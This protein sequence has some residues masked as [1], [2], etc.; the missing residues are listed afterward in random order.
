MV[1]WTGE[2][3]GHRHRDGEGGVIPLKFL[4]F[5]ILGPLAVLAVL[6]VLGWIAKGIGDG[7]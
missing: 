6:W 7:D 3:G 1:G 4:A 5:V 2:L